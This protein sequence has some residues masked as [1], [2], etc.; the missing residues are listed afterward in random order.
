MTLKSCSSKYFDENDDFGQ[1]SDEAVFAA[2]D[3]AVT[4]GVNAFNLSLGIPNGFTTMNTY[5]QAGYQQAYNRAH[6]SGITINISAGNDA[7][8]SHPGALVNGYTTL[9]LII[10]QVDSQDHCMHL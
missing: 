2:L 8:D 3:D 4:L 5:A 7:R 6:A 10:H 9:L 1:E